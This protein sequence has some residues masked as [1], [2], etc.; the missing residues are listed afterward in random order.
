ALPWN[1]VAPLRERLAFLHAHVAGWPDMSDAALTASLDRWLGPHGAGGRTLAALT[2]TRP[3][4]APPAPPRRG[5]RRALRTPAPERLEVPTGSMIA[6]DYSDVAAPVLAVRLQEVFGMRQTPR[7]AG[8]AVVMHLLSP[9]HRPMQVTRD[10]ESFW[11]S[12]YFD[13][14]KD[15]RGRY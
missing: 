11:K 7:L 1:G 14:R 2:P 6:I 10:L 3:R 13:V 5:Q 4:G 12:G 9:A 8:V 15:L